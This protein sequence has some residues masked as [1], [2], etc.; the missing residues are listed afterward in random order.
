MGASNAHVLLDVDNSLKTI[1]TWS[2]FLSSTVK[3]Q[4]GG[5]SLL[6]TVLLLLK[7]CLLSAGNDS[8]AAR[9]HSWYVTIDSAHLFPRSSEILLP[10]WPQQKDLPPLRMLARLFHLHLLHCAHRR[11]T[12]SRTRG[13]EGERTA[14]G[15]WSDDESR[16]RVGGETGLELR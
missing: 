3:E 6:D 15:R 14:K 4:P 2:G 10:P 9:K 7:T 5:I 16:G 1:L 8:A 13:P 11:G 12:D